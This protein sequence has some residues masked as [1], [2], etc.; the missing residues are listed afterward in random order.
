MNPTALFA[1]TLT[2]PAGC[3]DCP[4]CTQDGAPAAPGSAAAAK[5]EEPAKYRLDVQ[6]LFAQAAAMQVRL[7][8]PT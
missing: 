5:K 4:L 2:R 7:P 8:P 6:K 1:N 3:H